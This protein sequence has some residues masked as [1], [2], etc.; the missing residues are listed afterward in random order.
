MGVDILAVLR[1]PEVPGVAH[2]GAAPAGVGSPL[3]QRVPVPGDD[4]KQLCESG[5]Q[6]LRSFLCLQ[7]LLGRKITPGYHTGIFSVS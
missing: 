3:L 4:P 2:D 7:F 6:T 1:L 5:V